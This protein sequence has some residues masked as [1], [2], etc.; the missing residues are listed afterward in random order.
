M[1]NPRHDSN[2]GPWSAESSALDSSVALARTGDQA[3]LAAVRRTALLNQEST[4]ALD[5]LARLAARM[6]GTPVSLVSLIDEDR[7]YFA[8]HTGLPEQIAQEQQTPFTHS[9]CRYVV[10]DQAPVVI[11]DT[12]TDARASSNGAVTDLAVGAYAGVPITS[13]DGQL[14]GSFCAIDWQPREWSVDDLATLEDIG[15]AVAAEIESRALLIERDQEHARLRLLVAVGSAIT[16]N[17]QDGLAPAVAAELAP[18]ACDWCIVEIAEPAADGGSTRPLSVAIGA[19]DDDARTRV[20]RLHEAARSFPGWRSPTILASDSGLPVYI[21]HAT[22]EKLVEPEHRADVTPELLEIIHAAG[23]GSVS[24]FPLRAHGEPLGAITLVRADPSIGFSDE[25]RI[26]HAAVA[27]QLS[28]AIDAAQLGAE[29]LQRANAAQVIE[30][31]SDGVVLL[32]DDARVAVWNPSLARITGRDADE[33]MGRPIEEALPE[34]AAAMGEPAIAGS[35]RILRIAAPGGIR[36]VAVTGAS[37]GDGAVFALR[38]VTSEH[39]LERTRDEMV[40]TVSHQLRTPV[41]SVLAAAQTLQR[42]DIELDDATRDLLIDTIAQQGHRLEE[43]CDEVLLAYRLENG[44]HSVRLEPVE[45]DVVLDELITSMDVLGTGERHATVDASARGL[46]LFAD[47]HAMRQVMGNLLD[48]AFKYSPPGSEVR[49]EA[50]PVDEGIEVAVVDAGIGIP[51]EHHDAVF[52]RFHRLDPDMSRG[53]GGAG[54]GLFVVREL[55]HLMNGEVRIEPAEPFGTRMVITLP[56][57]ER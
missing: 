30:R 7:Q 14:L 13:P 46:R 40:A 28:L 34:L 3:R 6:L 4:P 29:V 39:L 10:L 8:G 57:A 20:E 56:V 41:T 51:H 25:E 33:A 1:V 9:L 48:N 32:D 11:N 43:L 55:V 23:I 26:L 5:R 35:G 18:A 53:V 27:R 24:S 49:V 19:P 12:H 54:L 22:L 15:A 47:D 52:E 44:V 31:I 2:P 45:L 17:Y 50:R 16:A 21:E 37:A 42:D 38:D 36:W